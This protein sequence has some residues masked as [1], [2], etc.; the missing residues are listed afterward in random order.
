[1]KPGESVRARR[2]RHAEITQHCGN[3][4]KQL[5]IKAGLTREEVGERVGQSASYIARLE[6]GR[7]RIC[8]F[9]FMDVAEAAG[10][11]RSDAVKE[12]WTAVAHL[13]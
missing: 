8:I 6:S 11:S 2:A 7:R 12:L 10:K 4:L 13:Y 3:Y 9:E 1:M 5:R